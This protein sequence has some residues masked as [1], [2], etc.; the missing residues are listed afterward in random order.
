MMEGEGVG[1]RSDEE[2]EG[3]TRRMNSFGFKGGKFLKKLV[4]HRWKSL[5]G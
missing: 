3:Q 2:R 1:E 4:L 5:S